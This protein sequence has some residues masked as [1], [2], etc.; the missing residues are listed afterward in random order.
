[1]PNQQLAVQVSDYKFLLK[2]Q[3]IDIE[4]IQA[5]VSIILYSAKFWQ[6]KT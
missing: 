6:V 2:R 4:A 5:L 1:M 3:Q